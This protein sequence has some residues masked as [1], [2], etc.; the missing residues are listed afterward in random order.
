MWCDPQKYGRDAG[1]MSIVV[2]A[3][4]FIWK[5]P[6]SSPVLEYGR[7]SHVDTRI[8]YGYFY[9]LG[10]VL[11]K[12]RQSRPPVPMIASVELEVR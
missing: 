9:T 6:D 10:L 8:Q 2:D 3:G 5:T 7:L 1:S 11:W 12:G 4:M